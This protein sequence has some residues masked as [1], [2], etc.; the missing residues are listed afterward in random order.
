MCAIGEESEK[1]NIMNR[2]RLKFQIIVGVMFVAALVYGISTISLIGHRPV[3]I[4]IV[5]ALAI[6]A[7]GVTF[8]YSLFRKSNKKTLKKLGEITILLLFIYGLTELACNQIYQNKVENILIEEVDL[9]KVSDG[10]YIGECSVDYIRAKVEVEVKAHQ[11]VNIELLEHIN[12]RGEKA[13]SIIDKIIEQQSIDVDAVTSATNSSKV[14]KQAV[15][16]A[17]LKGMK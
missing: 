9:S 12:E 10:I 16:N 4:F 7:L 8:G 3:V 13:E 6:L 14:I 11:I 1:E 5:E 17:L 2:R 15:E